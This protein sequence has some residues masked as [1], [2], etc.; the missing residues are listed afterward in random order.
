MPLPRTGH[1]PPPIHSRRPSDELGSVNQRISGGEATLGSL[2]GALRD[3]TYSLFILL[4]ALPFCTPIP[5]FGISMP[6]G[7][8]IAYLG[9]RLALGLEPHLP[10]R[11]RSRPVPPRVLGPLLRGAERLLRWLEKFMRPRLQFLTRSWLGRAVIGGM[12]TGSALLL[13]LP[14]PVPTSNF[15]PAITIVCLAAGLTED[16]GVTVLVGSALFAVTVAFFGAIAFYGTGAIE[17][18]WTW[19][20]R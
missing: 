16:D 12:I 13:M 19:W 20:L 11:F 15:F 8:V 5:M 17:S 7:A 10:E 4:I 3:R 1:R 2:M 6:F 18:V 14:L 9:L